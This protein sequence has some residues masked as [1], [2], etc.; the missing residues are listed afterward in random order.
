MPV[1]LYCKQ[2]KKV[3]KSNNN[4]DI[5]QTMGNSFSEMMQDTTTRALAITAL[6]VVSM[7]FLVIVSSAFGQQ[8]PIVVSAATGLAKPL[9]LPLISQSNLPDYSSF[10]S[11]GPSIPSVPSVASIIP[12]TP[13]LSSLSSTFSND[14]LN[15]P[16]HRNFQEH[17]QHTQPKP[18]VQLVPEKQWTVSTDLPTISSSPQNFEQTNINN[19][20]PTHKPLLQPRPPQKQIKHEAVQEAKQTHVRTAASQTPTFSDEET[21]QPASELQTKKPYLKPKLSRSHVSKLKQRQ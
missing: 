21:P 2:T 19:Q 12:H 14:P 1:L 20:K 9:V 7:L 11:P 4:R 8:A 10:V 15:F 16:S 3:D 18:H 17:R 6:V 5:R 13:S